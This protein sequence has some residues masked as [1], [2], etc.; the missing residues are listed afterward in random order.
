MACLAGGWV[1]AV[2]INE[3]RLEMAAKLGA[4]A[5]VDARRGPFHEEIRRLTAGEGADIVLEF[6]ANQ[7][8]LPSSFRSLKP[9]G[10]LVFV[11]YTPE[12]PMSVMPHE[13]VRNDLEIFGLRATTKL[14]LQDTMD[15]VAQ[16]RIKS[17][18]DQVF[19][20][21][22]VELAFDAREGRCYGR[23][24]VAVGW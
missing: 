11:G 17:V 22:D 15:L 2:D 16:G 23:A 8:T 4:H 6:V 19:S 21:E 1:I 20:R 12:L 24:V 13:L 3:A 14:E 9:V 7:D 5:L 10:R 18:I